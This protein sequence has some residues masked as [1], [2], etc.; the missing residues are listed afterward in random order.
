MPHSIVT[1]TCEGVADCV[2]A[3]PVAF[4]GGAFGGCAVWS[5]FAFGVCSCQPICKR[6]HLLSVVVLD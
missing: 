4:G 3:C 2:S 6:S 5:S 1:G